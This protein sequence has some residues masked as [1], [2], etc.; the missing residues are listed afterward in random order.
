VE[1][2]AEWVG[3][4]AC[5]ACHSG[6]ADFKDSPHGAG[7]PKTQ[8]ID[9]QKTCEFCHGPGS[10]HAGA[11]G[12]ISNPDI[13]KVRKPAKWSSAALNRFCLQCHEKDAGAKW[14]GSIHES[15]DVSCLACHTIHHA[16][17]NPHLGVRPSVKQVCF[18][19]H[20]NN[21]AFRK[22]GAHAALQDQEMDC[23]ACHNP[24]AL[25]E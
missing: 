21:R 5:L 22:I 8:N 6:M 14:M 13:K 3:A 18:Q 16:G 2:K 15:R 4:D 12:D 17:R 19:C 23:T 1:E 7:M 10:L 24:H 25:S 9:F 20:K 11:A